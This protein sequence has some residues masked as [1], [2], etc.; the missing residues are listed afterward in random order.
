[1]EKQKIV[2]IEDEEDI[3][4]ILEYNLQK[5]GYEVETSANGLEGLALIKKHTPSLVLLDIML[6]GLDGIEVC[7]KLKE[8]SST[9]D[10]PIIMVTAKG[11]ESDIVLGLGIGA[12][13]YVPK[14]F[15]P[16]ELLGRVKAVLRRCTLTKDH[17]TSDTIIREGIEVDSDRHIIKIDGKVVAF[18]VSE[19]RALQ[20]L[21]S[22]AGQVFTRDQLVNEV[23][24]EDAVVV[25]RNIDVHI[26]S[27]RKKIGKYR[28]LIETVRG[29]GYRFKDKE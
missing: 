24:G 2:V 28:N 6:P 8:N 15:S 7:R 25:D 18:T 29:I 4:E 3:C 12:D 22:S 5:N 20:T 17:S 14:P 27:V 13:D 16:K 11:E 19:F 23:M 1:M 26:R 9:R 21:A 10:I